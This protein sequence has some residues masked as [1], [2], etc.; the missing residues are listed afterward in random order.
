M[1]IPSLEIIEPGPLATVQDR[2]RPGYQ[3]LGVPVSGAADLYALR[4]GN[5]L[6]GNDPF[7]ASLEIT[8]GRFRAQ[9]LRD[10][11]FAVTGSNSSVFLNRTPIP[12]WR[13]LKA[14]RGQTIQLLQ[15]ELGFRHYLVLGGGIRV[16]LVLNSRSTYLRGKFGGFEGRALKAGDVLHTGPEATEPLPA[17]Y[18]RHLIPPYSPN[19]QLRV[20]LGPQDSAFSQRGIETF[21]TSAFSLTDRADRMGCRLAGPPIE[22]QRAPDILSDGVA[23]G[24]I[25]VPGNGQPLILLA[26]RP[27]T[28]GYAKIANVIAADI[29]LIAQALPGARITFKVISFHD[30]REIYLHKE[31]AIRRFLAGDEKAEA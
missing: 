30:A 28:G 4:I 9:F 10:T 19:P 21:I 15:T 22:H 12:T 24:A 16:P 20:I 14:R 29:P 8:L 7:D 31:F 26:D 23:M 2:G 3:H 5:L 6:V 18:P 27:T 1:N 25:Q 13:A 11:T 17:R